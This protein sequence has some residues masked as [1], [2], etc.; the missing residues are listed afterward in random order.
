MSRIASRDPAAPRLTGRLS[1]TDLLWV[2]NTAHGAGGHWHARIRAPEPDHDHLAAPQAALRYLVDHR[3]PT[4]PEPPD[5]TAL[6]E[7]AQIRTAVDRLVEPGADPWTQQ[8]RTLLAGATFSLD[9]QGGIA[10]TE[11]GW[12]GFC[13]DLLLPLVALAG[14]GAPLRRCANPACRLLFEDSSR[15][16]TRRWCDAAACGNRDRVRR[17][18]G[19]PGRS[20]AAD[21]FADERSGRYG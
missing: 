5:A 13:R 20:P 14:D 12:R 10:S 6:E 16:H 17:A 21:P 9:S 15:S 2:A 7:M 11:G 18:R 3:V 4:P 19:R 1:R 8:V